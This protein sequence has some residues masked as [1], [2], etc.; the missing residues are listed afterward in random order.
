MKNDLVEFLVWPDGL[1]C[2]KEDFE[3]EFRWI[4]ESVKSIKVPKMENELDEIVLLFD[5]INFYERVKNDGYYLGWQE[6][7]SRQEDGYRMLHIDS[8][9][10]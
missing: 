10:N 7:I 4:D 1:Y 9:E 8:H 3:N 2:K 5:E 6:S